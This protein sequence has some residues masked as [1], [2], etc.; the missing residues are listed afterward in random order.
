MLGD[1]VIL[2]MVFLAVRRRDYMREK[3]VGIPNPQKNPVNLFG[4]K[5][6]DELIRKVGSKEDV[7]K[8]TD[9]VSEHL[10]DST[11]SLE[12]YGLTPEVVAKLFAKGGA[13]GA[14]AKVIDIMHKVDAERI[15][16]EEFYS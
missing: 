6:A 11:N 10:T 16:G 12:T 9:K 15:L 4:K 1:I 3:R 2:R 5:Y 13:L 8:F 7:L 14:A